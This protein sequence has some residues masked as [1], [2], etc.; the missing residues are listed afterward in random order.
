MLWLVKSSF[1]TTS[2]S[3]FPSVPAR[4]LQELQFFNSICSASPSHAHAPTLPPP[5]ALMFLLLFLTLF[6]P[7]SACPAFY[8]ILTMFFPTGISNLPDWLSGA[9]WS[10]L[11]PSHSSP[12]PLSDVNPAAPHCQHLGTDTQ[13]KCKNMNVTLVC[14]EKRICAFMNT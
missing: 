11:F 8:P 2:F 4:V 13:H 10:R 9:T 14:G 12:C 1:S 5:P 7:F 3:L 6:P